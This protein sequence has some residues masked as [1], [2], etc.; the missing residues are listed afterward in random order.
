[1]QTLQCYQESVVLTTQSESAKESYIV[2][3]NLWTERNKR[4][5][6]NGHSIKHLCQICM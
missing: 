6:L 4:I 1:M 5:S 3:I 2:H